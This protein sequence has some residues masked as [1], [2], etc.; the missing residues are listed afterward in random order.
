MKFTINA[1][2]FL[3]AAQTTGSV[4]PR[5][6]TLPI[7][8]HFLL[9]V[10]NGKVKLTATNQEQIIISSKN[11]EVEREGSI[12]VPGHQLIAL[13]NSNDGEI[14]FDADLESNN[15]N[16]K[17]ETGKYKLE[18]INYE[19]YLDINYNENEQLE[20]FK[21]ENDLL[22]QME[23][24]AICCSTDEFKPSITGVFF[25]SNGS[26]LILCATDSYR[27]AW[28]KKDAQKPQF[29]VIL[30][31]ESINAI[32]KFAGD[33]EMAFLNK[34]RFVLKN[35]NAILISRLVNEK[36]PQWETVI[37]KVIDGEMTA[38]LSELKQAINRVS[39]FADNS[40]KIDFNINDKLIVG[41]SDE[42]NSANEQLD[43]KTNKEFKLFFNYKFLLEMLKL[44]KGDLVKFGYSESNRPVMI[45]SDSEIQSIILPI[46]N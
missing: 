15:I 41:S 11:A 31:K 13:L 27:M 35:E 22:R 2:S 21:V 23:Q 8:E 16:I 24:I 40:F 14:I 37:P 42:H 19:E 45:N 4:L 3:Q 26:Q 29:E 34:D 32:G 9:E 30:P 39:L 43:I 36:F 25:H 18:G 38:G 17:T 46:R 20:Y 44:Q 1:K 7:L 33:C 12:L 28:I 6:S 5:K 10:E